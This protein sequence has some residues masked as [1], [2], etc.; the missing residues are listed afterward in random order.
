MND[1]QTFDLI[2]VGTGVAAS[3]IASRCAKAGWKIAIIDER[4]F[5]GTCQL[6]GCDP[7]KVLRRGAEV[8][9]AARLMQGKGIDRSD[10]LRID[11][12]KLVKF[13]RTFTESVPE[14]KEKSFKDSGMST[15]HGRAAFVD[16]RTLDVGGQRVQADRI[17]LANGSRP[18]PLPIDGEEHLIHS[19]QF[20]ELETLPRRLVFA[21]GGYITF[22]FAHMAARAGAEVTILE[23]SER[24]LGP[25]DADLVGQLV[26]R[27]RAAGIDV[28]M[29]AEVNRIER[30][31]DSFAV[32][33]TIDDKT[34]TFDA[35][36]VVHG[37]GRVPAT[38]GLEL[39][40][41]G[42]RYDKPGV[43]V[44]EFLQSVSNPAV[45]A[46]GDV[47]ATDGPPLTPVAGLEGGAVATNLLEGNNKTVDYS[48]VPSCVFTI[49]PLASVGLSESDAKEQGVDCDCQFTDMSSWYLARRVGETHAAAKVLVGKQDGRI[50][51]AH[52]LGPECEQMI[53]FF[54]IA[55]RKGWTKDDL[56]DIVS[57][58]PSSA[59]YV[60]SLL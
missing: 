18:M 5:G 48:G 30:S 22:E 43:E 6:R 13:K 23:R 35:D 39:Q 41:G 12:R 32:T 29:K 50:L 4:P 59:S 44:N 37:A 33:A 20:M 45:Y 54:A 16:E 52:L 27:S 2:V 25:F 56:S 55:V 24:P 60:A 49:P 14:S 57:A 28:R 15:F 51:G 1:I 17:A 3:S 42:V 9:E 7:K 10:E 11:W 19:D 40:R 53:N 26:E 31:G 34:E 8:I 36:G 46:A 21:G 58:Y 47:A 38:E